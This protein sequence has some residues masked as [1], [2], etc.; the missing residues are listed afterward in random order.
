[1]ITTPVREKRQVVPRW[2]SLVATLAAQELSV[3]LR[4]DHRIV[5]QLP[6]ELTACLE[7]WRRTPSLVTAAELVE[8]AIV[9]GR[10]REAAEAARYLTNYQRNATPLILARADLVLGRIGERPLPSMHPSGDPRSTAAYWRRLTRINPRDPLAWVELALHQTIGGHSAH[11]RRSMT[12]ARQVAPE[13]RHVLRSAARM[14]L[15]QGS[16]DEAHAIVA[17]SRATKSDPWLMAAE[18][19]L[20]SVADRPP[21]L[22]K[23]GRSM[24]DDAGL[25]PRQITELA[26]AIATVELHAGRYK[27]SRRS[28]EASM[29]DPT[30]NAIAQAEWATPFLGFE[31]VRLR[32]LTRTQDAHEAYALHLYRCQEFE[33]V[34]QICERWAESDAYSERPF[35]LATTAAGL[36]GNFEEAARFARQGLTKKPGSV[37]FSNSLAFA[38]GSMGNGDEA[39]KVLTRVHIGETEPLLSHVTQANRGLA[40]FRKGLCDLGM[41]RYQEAIDGFT[42]LSRLDLVAQA[43]VYL[44]REALLAGLP[45]ADELLHA[46]GNSVRSAGRTE[47]SY[48]LQQVLALVGSRR[49]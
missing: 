33:Q 45:T 9:N 30:G 13:N 3:H 42:K 29:K 39:E 46:A 48:A 27:K 44:A 32:Q 43:R 16:P 11:A 7:R 47:A 4:R 23:V 34:P 17:R 2:R 6:P 26:G 12:I 5:H 41:Q 22:V 1:M 28:F 37:A 24:I 14:A 15:H 31:M 35:Q 38:L 36:A 20:A 8:C 19:A 10:E 18:I 40:A 49:N 21:S 25:P